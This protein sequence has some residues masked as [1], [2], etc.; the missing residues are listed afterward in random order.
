MSRL[1]RF[2]NLKHYPFLYAIYNKLTLSEI[3]ACET[4]LKQHSNL[5]KAEFAEVANNW[6]LDQEAKP[7]NHTHMWALVTE[8]NSMEQPAEWP[9]EQFN[10]YHKIKE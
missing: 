1:E 3:S 6:M 4:F 10:A 7:K 9:K 2:N 5:S 8:L